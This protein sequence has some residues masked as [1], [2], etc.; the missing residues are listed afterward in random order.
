MFVLLLIMMPLAT[1]EIGTD[2]WITGLM[3]NVVKASAN[4]H[5]GWVLVHTSAIMMVLRFFCW[6]DRAQAAAS[7]TLDH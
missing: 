6:S 4:F 2:A 3:E 1:T 7:A 5:P